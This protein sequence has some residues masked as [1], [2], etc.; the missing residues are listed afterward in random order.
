LRF[1][2]VALFALLGTLVVLS[3]RSTKR[4]GAFLAAPSASAPQVEDSISRSQS[5]D[6]QRYF[7]E[8]MRSFHDGAGQEI[9]L[10]H[11]AIAADPQFGGA[12]LRLWALLSGP[13]LTHWPR[14][15][16]ADDYK[17]R[18]LALKATLSRRD[19][20]LFEALSRSTSD[21]VNRALDAYL[22]VHPDDDPAWW[23]RLDGT[24][25]TS[26]RALAARPLFVSVMAATAVD[27][28]SGTAAGGPG[29]P[30]DDAMKR[31]RELAGDCL[32]VSP[33]AEQCFFVRGYVLDN[34]GDCEGAFAD[35][36]RVVE[37]NPDLSEARFR[38]GGLLASRGATASVIRQTLGPDTREHTGDGSI[39]FPALIPM[40]EGDFR[41]VERIA[42]ELMNRAGAEATEEMH[43]RQLAATRVYAKIEFDDALG[44]ARV[45]AEYL[46]LRAAWKDFDAEWAS[47]LIGAAARGGRLS[48]L[49]AERMLDETFDALARRFDPEVAWA[50][51]Y[52][53]AS[54]TRGEASTAVAKF[55]SLHRPLPTTWKGAATRAF[56]LAGRGEVAR[57]MLQA[58]ARSCSAPLLAVRSWIHAQLYLGELDEQKGDKASA[59]AHYV[60]VISR[61]GHAIPR[62]VTADEARAH[63]R[64]LGCDLAAPMSAQGNPSAVTASV[65]SP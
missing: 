17:P 23:A 43:M 46:D 9:R 45:A 6:A 12:Y 56:F 24:S 35:F 38:L 8:A 11:Q 28:L 60:T 5:P 55:D 3:E 36:R 61:W 2:A 58:V 31:A 57:S 48:H 47:W 19:V 15:E 7:E 64:G 65:P 53:S 13:H 34:E 51:T 29:R 44:A 63:A 42:G 33:R 30:F 39:V 49:A 25:A 1:A 27:L 22:A 37:L 52:A 18:V 41:E 14:A 16:H 21:D 32:K 20:T 50:M 59:C 10:L 62:S 4:D 26:D 40:F 54:E